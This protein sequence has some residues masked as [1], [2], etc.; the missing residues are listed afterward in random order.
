MTFVTLFINIYSDNFLT[1]YN[2]Y[3]QTNRYMYP[4]PQNEMSEHKIN[5]IVLLEFYY[6]CYI[7][8]NYKNR[9]KKY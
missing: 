7:I 6:Y 9:T 1:Y 2:N 5:S 3:T 8:H 4:H